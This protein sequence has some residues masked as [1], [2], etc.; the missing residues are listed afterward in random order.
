MT[1]PACGPVNFI[2]FET[3]IQSAASDPVSCLVIEDFKKK[4]SKEELVLLAQ[5]VKVLEV[6][7]P[8]MA[9]DKLQGGAKVDEILDS[10]IE[11]VSVVESTKIG[12]LS[13]DTLAVRCDKLRRFEGTINHLNFRGL[14]ITEIP[15]D[16]KRLRIKSIGCAGTRLSSDEKKSLIMAALADSEFKLTGVSIEELGPHLEMALG[17]PSNIALP[18]MKNIINMAFSN[19]ILN[20]KI[21][22]KIFND[23]PNTEMFWLISSFNRQEPHL[24]ESLS[25]IP[26]DR[27]V[28]FAKSGYLS[29]LYNE[30]GGPDCFRMLRS[31]FDKCSKSSIEMIMN[32]LSQEKRE[33][34]IFV[35]LQGSMVPKYFYLHRDDLN[36][37]FAE[38]VLDCIPD[39]T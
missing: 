1:S 23:L 35:G 16:V 32:R 4:Y 14:D 9:L 28:Q 11:R 38:M 15:I 3:L 13:S 36:E 24:L 18:I 25:M 26:T 37:A 6:D 34:I 33:T 17:K 5:R 30:I 39:A 12:I 19:Q 29:D 21:M 27:F 7:S 31:I 20:P 8:L 2:F 10:V 22:A